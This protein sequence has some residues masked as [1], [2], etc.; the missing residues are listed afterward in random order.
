MRAEPQTPAEQAPPEAQPVAA[1]ERV[2]APAV[3]KIQVAA[4]AES[5]AAAPAPEPVA[6]PDAVVHVE[7]PAASADARPEPTAPPVQP[8][9]VIDVET[10]LAQSGLVMIQT[11]PA[12]ARL[13]EPE[14]EPQIVPR[15]PRPRRPPPPDTGP[16][17]IVETH[18][19]V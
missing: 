12:K 17:Q 14:P 3:D 11:D 13:A 19:S 16:L 10:A 1:E 5:P 6:V 4:Q 18:K 15:V 7:P 2:A 8:A 9:T